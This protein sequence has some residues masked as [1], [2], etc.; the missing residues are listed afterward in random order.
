MKTLMIFLFALVVGG[1]FAGPGNAAWS[2]DLNRPTI[3]AQVTTLRIVAVTDTSLVLTWTEVS[4]STTAVNRYA[5]RFSSPPLNWPARAD[6]TTGNCGA[7]VYGSTA[8]GGRTR[9][10]VLTGLQPATAYDVQV[11]S[12]TGV[13]NSTAVFGPLSNIA[14]ATTA[15]R[16]GPMMVVRPRMFLDTIGAVRSFEVGSFGSWRWP[17]SAVFFSGDYAV[18]FRDVR[19][20]VRAYGYLLIVKP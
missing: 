20:S 16:V 6:V 15:E 11:I 1:Y 18:T 10:C 13:L 17:L 4:S 9:A 5:V 2:K 12:Y 3:P 7:P 14:T 19:D 8:A